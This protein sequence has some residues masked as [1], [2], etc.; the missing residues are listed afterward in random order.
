[1]FEPWR[2]SETVKNRTALLPFTIYFLKKGE[3]APDSIFASVHRIRFTAFELIY[4]IR[5]QIG[6]GRG[7]HP[8]RYGGFGAGCNKFRI[9]RVR[10]FSPK[11]VFKMHV[12]AIAF[13]PES[14]HQ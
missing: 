13:V 2:Y 10:R 5:V 14:F 4:Q 7:L 1:M 6:E 3:R 11:I 8:V 9:D 12:I